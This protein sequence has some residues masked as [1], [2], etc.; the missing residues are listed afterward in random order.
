[1]SVESWPLRAVIAVGTAAVRQGSP[2]AGVPQ[3]VGGAGSGATGDDDNASRRG[4]GREPAS[5]L[6]GAQ[7]A[8]DSRGTPSG[9]S[10]KGLWLR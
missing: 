9:M 4:G 10:G 2:G 5:R 1:M 6:G 7:Q 8:E 3:G